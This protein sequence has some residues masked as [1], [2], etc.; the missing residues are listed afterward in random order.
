MNPLLNFF[1]ADTLGALM[2]T[3]FNDVFV[4]LINEAF[5]LFDTMLFDL[6][7][8]MLF[9]EELVSIEG[10]TFL[11]ESAIT[12]M[13]TFIYGFCCALVVL[14]FLSKGFKIYILWRDG[15]ADSSPADM[16]VGIMQAA[17][18]MV[19]F[20]LIYRYM[21]SITL[22]LAQNL[23]ALMGT[24][25]Y[26]SAPLFLDPMALAGQGILFLL[27]LLIYVIAI[28]IL[29]LQLLGRGFELLILR[30]GI[31][32]ACLGLIDSDM[33]IFKGYIQIFFKAMLT[34]VVQILLLSLSLKIVT[35][36]HNMNV[37]V[38][39]V[40]LMAAFKTPNLLQQILVQN[41]GSGVMQKVQ[42]G[43]MLASSIK[44]LMR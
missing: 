24:Y 30:L 29:W 41:G 32:F 4:N 5:L 20:P 27:F 8:G 26:V 40:V 17:V 25:E 1:G 15:D 31:P 21:V 38:G 16:V 34:S 33:G 22:F 11:S 13:F 6:L 2:I 28:F 14:K 35:N 19:S 23:L 43:A 39:L 37:M 9:A 44:G 10:A 42:S 7:S 12:A 18:V 36:L 3:M